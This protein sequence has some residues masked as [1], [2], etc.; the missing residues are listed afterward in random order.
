MYKQ[1]MRSQAGMTLIEIMVVIAIVAGL[2]GIIGVSV[3]GQRDKANIESTAIQINNLMDA[4]NLYK[5][6]ANRFPSTEQGLDALVEK[7]GIGKV[8]KN[9]PPEGYLDK[10]PKDAWGNDFEYAS[11]GTHGNRVEI[12]SCGPDEECDTEDDVKSWE[13]EDEE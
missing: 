13:S 12:W 2:A 10:L 7:P 5:L 4:L 9:Y 1:I 6:D 11:P 8:P 3:F